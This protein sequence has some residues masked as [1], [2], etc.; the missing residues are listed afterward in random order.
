MDTRRTGTAL[1]GRTP[2]PLPLLIAAA[3]PIH[4]ERGRS[5]ASDGRVAAASGSGTGL[6]LGGLGGWLVLAAT[7]LRL[8]CSRL[9]VQGMGLGMDAVEVEAV[10]GGVCALEGGMSN[11]GVGGGDGEAAAGAGQGGDASGGGGKCAP[12][13]A[14]HCARWNATRA[15]CRQAASSS[16]AKSSRSQTNICRRHASEVRANSAQPQPCW[17][18]LRFVS[19]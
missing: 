8:L 16:G 10:S 9:V 1:P 4:A 11:W 13:V 7:W 15:P 18:R 17:L 12:S 3:P 2:L 14:M 19:V 6:G 5:V